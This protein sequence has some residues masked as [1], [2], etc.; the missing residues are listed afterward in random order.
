[1]LA[2]LAMSACLPCHASIVESYSQTGMARSF[3]RLT[4]KSRIED[5]EHNNQFIHQASQSRFEMT[6]RD[7]RFY[8]K[9]Q[10]GPHTTEKEIHYV[11]GSG[12]H[13]RSYVH[14]TPQG[15][16]L[17]LPVSWYAK[18][19]GGYWQMAPGFDHPDQPHFRRRI[20]YDCFFC[21][22]AYPNI[23]AKADVADPLYLEPL[24]QGIDC[25]RCHGPA[26][27][28]LKRPSKG[29]IL[30]PKSLPS[31]RQTELCMQCHLETTSQPLPFA[32]RRT[33]RT[34]FSYDPR[35]PLSD[36]MIHFDHDD[37]A[38]WNEKFEVVSAPYRM[39]QSK[40]FQKSSG[41]LTC[42]TCHNP[43]QPARANDQACRDCHTAAHRNTAE[44]KQNCTGCH[45]AKRN[46]EDAPLTKFTDHKISRI[47]E[48][49]PGR[50]LPP[51]KGKVRV[52]WPPNG[53][54]AVHNNPSSL[55]A[56][57]TLVLQRFP[58]LASL[59]TALSTWPDDP[60]LLTVYGEALRRAGQ[61]EE[62]EKALR[63]AIAADPDQPE[64]Y[65][66]L[67]VLLAQSSRPSE[68][69]AMFRSALA[70]DPRNRAANANL[71]LLDKP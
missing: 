71:T 64:P 60:F 23:P 53:V 70:I 48:T 57:R 33:G 66:N 13:A 49:S 17:A 9:R 7:G 67:G 2:V 10:S 1:M 68:A 16:L 3:Y 21:H 54:T 25:T 27:Q 52:Y 35:E 65:V 56:S 46:P 43:H 59:R 19:G 50:T 42:V 40:C 44:I 4:A 39:M 69:A 36:Y 29:N 55:E 41:R 15:R 62:A 28:H 8:M 58:D 30:N 26:D 45:M 11:L 47:P 22:N 51:Y 12:N 61:L 14:V 37:K 31:A 20:G 63:K 5:F 38:P 32:V 34:M 18:E 24:P 6:L